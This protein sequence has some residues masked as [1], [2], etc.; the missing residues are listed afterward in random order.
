MDRNDYLSACTFFGHR[1]APDTLY[2][3]LLQSIEQL[4]LQEKVT[5]FYVGNHGAFDRLAYH[6]LK[7]LQKH[8]SYIRINVVLAYMPTRQ[9]TYDENRVLPEGIELVPKRF[10]ISYRNNWMLRRCSYVISYITHLTGGAAQF[11]DKARKQKK[12]IIAIK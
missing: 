6:A 1:E 2:P 11:V 9:E 4:I 5:C 7:Q 12:I 3:T 8:Y 10:A